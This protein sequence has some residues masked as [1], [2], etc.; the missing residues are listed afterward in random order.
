MAEIYQIYAFEEIII[1]FWNSEK[2]YT[3]SV[4]SSGESS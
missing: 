1:E 2:V 4:H 3:I